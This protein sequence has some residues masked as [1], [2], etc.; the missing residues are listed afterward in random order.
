[1]KVAVVFPDVP[2]AVFNT[3]LGWYRAIKRDP[4]VESAVAINAHGFY[5]LPDEPLDKLTS[6]DVGVTVVISG[7]QVHDRM[8]ARSIPG[9]AKALVLTDEPYET[10]STALFNSETWAGTYSA[11]YTNDSSSVG[12]HQQ[13]R[14]LPCAYD[15]TVKPEQYDKKPFDIGFVG[16]TD[17][18]REQWLGTVDRLCKGR[19][20][21]VVGPKW[22]PRFWDR[23]HS[24]HTRVRMDTS[25][26][27]GYFSPEE[28]ADLYAKCKIVVN[29]HR[30]PGSSPNPRAFDLI[31]YGIPA[32]QDVRADSPSS[33]VQTETPE[34]MGGLI[35]AFLEGD[36]LVK[37]LFRRSVNVGLECAPDHTYDARWASVRQDLKA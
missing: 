2:R 30:E 11:V 15:A 12:R 9:T 1:M 5:D 3:A 4:G 17:D 10:Q 6:L 28:V 20:W 7:R 16:T 8:R 37:E 25:P 32:V 18:R 22:K 35:N 21:C 24:Q 23:T 19:T 36:E 13:G 34:K 27:T 33:V 29:V 26:S 14:F 31:G